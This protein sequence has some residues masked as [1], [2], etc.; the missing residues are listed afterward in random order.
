MDGGYDAVCAS[1]GP[2]EIA[3]YEK[4]KE[5]T[6]Y[7]ISD[8]EAV[9][10]HFL[11]NFGETDIPD[12][13]YSALADAC[14][15]RSVPLVPLD[16]DDETFSEKYCENVGTMELLKETNLAKRLFRKKFDLSSPESFVR[17]WD[18]SVNK[19]KGLRKMSE[20][21][22]YFIAGSIRKTA[23]GKNRVLAVIDAERA[24]GIIEHLTEGSLDP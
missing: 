1:A 16:M 7:G 13:S 6:E 8:L 17:E 24:D 14:S 12:P 3:G 2:E 23:C 9:Y 15:E 20:E 22:E 19:I 4:R 10:I 21:R 18:C 11:K 5:I